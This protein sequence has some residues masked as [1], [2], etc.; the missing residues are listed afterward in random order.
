[1]Q[2]GERQTSRLRS[3]YLEELLKKDIKFF[4]TEGE[5]LNLVYH[6]SND[7]ILVQDAIGDKVCIF[8]LDFCQHDIYFM[9]NK[10]VSLQDIF[11]VFY[12]FIKI[13]MLFIN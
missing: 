7:A 2:T 5:K 6:I 11:K 13:T 9:W 4:D 1:M 10:S 3:K 8:L 12:F